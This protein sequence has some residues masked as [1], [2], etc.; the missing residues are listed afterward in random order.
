MTL[1]LLILDF[2]LSDKLTGCLRRKENPLNSETG[3]R[4]FKDRYFSAA[5]LVWQRNMKIFIGKEM[6]RSELGDIFVPLDDKFLLNL[7]Q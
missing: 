1:G 2:C 7:A 4:I 6:Q 5:V 3:F